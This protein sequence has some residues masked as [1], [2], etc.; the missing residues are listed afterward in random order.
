MVKYPWGFS[1]FWL[2]SFLV[3][4]SVLLLF[5]LASLLWPQFFHPSHPQPLIV[6]VDLQESPQ[7]HKSFIRD[8]EVPDPVKQKSVENSEEPALFFSKE[9]RRFQKQTRAPVYGPN[10]NVLPQQLLPK[11][12]TASIAPLRKGQ[13]GEDESLSELQRIAQGAVAHQGPTGDMGR[14]IVTALSPQVSSLSS[15]VPEDIE[16]G[17]FTA[18]NTD[19]WTYYT[20]FERLED[21]VRPL[22]VQLVRDQVGRISPKVIREYPR[23][24][25]STLMEIQL[26]P[27]GEVVRI[28]LLRS[29]GLR[30]LDQAHAE[31][32]WRTKV[33]ENPPAELVEEDGL[34]HLRYQF[35]VVLRK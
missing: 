22:W 34:V 29:S 17:Q 1:L 8:I 4:L 7:T 11:S 14:Q 20:F 35:F 23:S 33:I 12:R 26:N 2:V 10:R 32:F 28:L 25:A 16:V 13:A 5:L 18:I 6:E 27:K 31:A 9:S 15:W 3:H 19:R 21:K 24:I 30:E